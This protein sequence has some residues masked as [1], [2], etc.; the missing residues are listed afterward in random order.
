MMRPIND[1]MDG[2]SEGARDEEGAARSNRQHDPKGQILEEGHPDR[3]EKEGTG[4]PAANKT[5]DSDGVQKKTNQKF[6]LS[7]IALLNKQN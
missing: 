5:A 7:C 4:N 3:T 2:I 6:H 1:T